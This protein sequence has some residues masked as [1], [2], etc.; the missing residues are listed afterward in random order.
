MT[1]N[2]ALII[3]SAVVITAVM[4]GI[5]NPKQTGSLPPKIQS[6]VLAMELAGRVSQV[7]AIVGQQREAAEKFCYWLQLNTIADFFFIASYTSMYF[8][9]GKLMNRRVGFLVSS[10]ALVTSLA[11]VCENL[12]LLNTAHACYSVHSAAVTAWTRDCSLI[13][14]G[15]LGINSALAA[16]LF[17]I[18]SKSSWRLLR[19][20]T[21]IAYFAAGVLFLLGL[22]SP[23]KIRWALSL[24]PLGIVLQFAILLRD[25]RFLKEYEL[26]P[27]NEN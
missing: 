18:S 12:G 9:F 14:W 2:G 25:K 19:L 27:A 7:K 10:V 13:K 1:R 17:W 21:A 3:T 20:I 8:M 22:T 11:D 26:I 23:D 4:T 24:F 5:L 6:P 15:F 16:R